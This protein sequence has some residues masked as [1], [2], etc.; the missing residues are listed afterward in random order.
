MAEL[1]GCARGLRR[2]P[3]CK[4]FEAGN[5][6]YDIHERHLVSPNGPQ[7]NE[8]GSLWALALLYI[9]FVLLIL[10]GIRIAIFYSAC[11]SSIAANA[12]S[13]PPPTHSRNMR[14]SQNEGPEL[15]RLYRHARWGEIPVGDASRLATILAAMRQCLEA[16]E[17]ER[18]IVEMEVALAVNTNPVVP[19][20]KG[21]R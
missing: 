13:S 19:F 6:S 11:A 12:A 17:L 1:R 20:R 7:R 16:S 4:Q 10:F 3:N 21:M 18:R 8:V 5:N 14:T 9:W 2:V 15:G